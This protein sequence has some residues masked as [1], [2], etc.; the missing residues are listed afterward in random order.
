[1]VNGDPAQTPAK[2]HI[3]NPS[4]YGRV[5]GVILTALEHRK[6]KSE[7]TKDRSLQEK[8]FEVLGFS[9]EEV[10]ILDDLDGCVGGGKRGRCSF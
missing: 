7:P 10:Q 2:K 1:M 9:K 4:I 3:P 6:S 8:V 5:T